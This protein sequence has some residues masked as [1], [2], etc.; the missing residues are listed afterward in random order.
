MD[1]TREQS[2]TATESVSEV[3]RE[4][5]ATKHKRL[6]RLRVT[7]GNRDDADAI[8]N[9]FLPREMGIPKGDFD[10]IFDDRAK[11]EFKEAQRLVKDHSH[12][13]LSPKCRLEVIMAR[14]RKSPVSVNKHSVKPHQRYI[15]RNG[16]QYIVDVKGHNPDDKPKRMSH[17][18][19]MAIIDSLTKRP[20]KRIA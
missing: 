12:L 16:N 19:K 13:E 20:K 8:Y 15:W 9:I 5:M 10:I 17:A 6:G 11:D 14:K 2:E 4:T 18:E 7:G 1:S 3:E